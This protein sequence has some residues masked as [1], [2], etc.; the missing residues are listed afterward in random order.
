MRPIRALLL[1]GLAAG[2]VTCGETTEPSAPG[3]LIVR[4][5][6]PNTDD[7][8]ILF[9]IS[10]GSVDSVRSSYPDLFIEKDSLVTQVVVAGD[11][12]AGGIV[13]IR[14]PDVT[15]L[16]SY[17]ATVDQV[18]TRTTFAQRSPQ[19]YSLAVERQ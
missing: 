9:T 14:V 10:G 3:W 8:G 12:V 16:G 7:G 17:A 1:L 6:T 19:Q 4:L 5:S 2:L 15:A 18:A 13:E 11:I